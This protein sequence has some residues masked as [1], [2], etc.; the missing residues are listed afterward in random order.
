MRRKFVDTTP[1]VLEIPD[2]TPDEELPPERRWEEED[3]VTRET[4]DH[5]Q[6]LQKTDEA[7]D[8]DVGEDEYYEFPF[9]TPDALD[10]TSTG[11]DEPDVSSSIPDDETVRDN[12]WN[13]NRRRREEEPPASGKRVRFST[14]E[15]EEASRENT[16]DLTKKLTE[17]L[18]QQKADITIQELF[19][20]APYCKELMVKRLI[21]APEQKREEE[22]PTVTVSSVSPWSDTGPVVQVQ[23]K[24]MTLPNILVDG[25]SGANVISAQL[26]S[27]LKGLQLL[28]AP[29]NLK[30][31]DQRRVLPLGVIKELPIR[32]GDMSFQ[33]DAVVLPVSASGEQVP[34]ILGRP[35]LRKN[36]IRQEWDASKDYMELKWRGENRRIKTK[37]VFA[38]SYEDM[39][40]IPHVVSQHRIK[41]L[42]TAKP[43]VQRPYRMNPNYA[44][45]VRKEIEKLKAANFIFPVK[46]YDWLSPI[47]IVSKKNGTL[48]VCVDYRKLNEHTVKDPYPLPFIDDILDKVAGKEA[49]T[50]MDGFSGYNQVS[51]A[52]EDQNKTAFITP[53]GAYAYSRMPFGLSGAP[54]TFQRLVIETFSEYIGDFMEA[55]LDDFTVYG[56]DKR[57]LEQLEKALV[58]CLDK[59]LSLNPDKCVFWTQSG[60][61]LGHIICKEGILMDPA[62]IEKILKQPAPT[63]RKELQRVMGM[64]NF[65]RRYILN[66]AVITAPVNSLDRDDVP[67]EWDKRCDEAF[68]LLKEKMT[69][70][71]ILRPPRWD[72]PFHIHTD[73]SGV[74]VGAVLAQPQDPKLDLPIY[75]A[76]RTLNKNER[77][78]TTTE[79]E[80]LAMVYAEFD[81]TVVYKPGKLNMV[82]DQ[83][84]RQELGREPGYEDDS[85]PDE[86]LLSITLDVPDDHPASGSESEGSEKTVPSYTALLK[87]GWQSPL[88]YFLANGELPEDTPYHLKRRITKKI[89]Q[90]TLIHGELYKRGVDQIL[91]RCVNEEDVLKIMEEAHE[92]PSGGHGAG[93]ATAQKILH[94]GLWWPTLFKDCHT[95]VKS[96]DECQR[97]LTLKEGMPLKPIYP[98]GIFQRWGLDFIGPIKPA[99]WPTGRRYII[100]ATDYTTKWIEAECYRTN[101]KKVTAKFIYENII[102]RFGVPLEFVSD[103]G[104]HFLNGVMEE[105][106]THYQIKHR[107]STAYYPQCNGQ[108]ESTNKILISALRKL[109]EKHRHNWDA[110]VPSVLWAM[111]TA[112]KA[113]TNH[114][115]FHMVYGVEALVPMEFI[116]P[117]LRIATEY[118]L[119]AEEGIQERLMQLLKLEE[120]R[121]VAYEHQCGIQNRRKKY[122]DS[123]RKMFNLKKDDKV[124]H[125]VTT[126]KIKKRKLSYIWEGPFIVREVY[127]NGTFK[128]SDEDQL[129]V[130][131]INGNKL[132]PYDIRNFPRGDPFIDQ[133][134]EIIWEV[135]N[136]DTGPNPEEGTEVPVGNPDTDRNH[137]SMTL[138]K[139]VQTSSRKSGYE[140]IIWIKRQNNMEDPEK[141]PT[142][143]YINNT[144]SRDIKNFDK[145]G[146]GNSAPEFKVEQGRI[147]DIDYPCYS[148]T[149]ESVPDEDHKL[150][151]ELLH[152]PGE[153][154]GI[155]FCLRYSFDELTDG[156]HE[157]PRTKLSRRIRSAMHPVQT[158][159]EL[160]TSDMQTE[161]LSH[162]TLDHMPKNPPACEVSDP[163]GEEDPVSRLLAEPIQKS[164]RVTE[165]NSASADASARG[166]GASEARTDRT[167][168]RGAERSRHPDGG[169]EPQYARRQQAELGLRECEIRRES[170]RSE[171]LAVIRTGSGDCSR[172]TGLREEESRPEAELIENIL[173]VPN[174]ASNSI[175]RTERSL[176]RSVLIHR[177]RPILRPCR[178]PY[179]IE[180]MSKKGSASKAAISELHTNNEELLIA[181]DKAVKGRKILACYIKDIGNLEW[182]DE[183][184]AEQ[185]KKQFGALITLKLTQIQPDLIAQLANA[186][187]GVTNRVTISKAS[188][189]I[190]EDLIQDVFNLPN[191]GVTISKLPVLDSDWLAVAYPEYALPAKNRK[192]YYTAARCEHPDW[193]SKISWVIRYVLGRA[194]G[195]KISKGVLA[196]MLEA[197]AKGVTVNWAQV[198]TDRLRTELR[199]LKL[200]TKGEFYR[201]EAG[202]QLTMLGLYMLTGRDF[203]SDEVKEKTGSK[204]V[205]AKIEKTVPDTPSCRTRGKRKAPEPKKVVKR[206]NRRRSP[207]MEAEVSSPD[208]SSEEESEGERER[209]P[210]PEY[211]REGPH[212]KKIW[213]CEGPQAAENFQ[214]VSR[215]PKPIVVK[216]EAGE[217]SAS[218]RAP[219]GYG[220][221]PKNAPTVTE[222]SSGTENE[223]SPQFPIPDP[224][225]LAQA[226]FCWEMEPDA[227]GPQPTGSRSTHRSGDRYKAEYEKTVKGKEISSPPT[228]EIPVPGQTA[229]GEVRPWERMGM[230]TV[231]AT[232]VIQDIIR[233]TIQPTTEPNPA[234]QMERVRRQAEQANRS[235]DEAQ[236]RAFAANPLPETGR[237]HPAVSAPSGIDQAGFFRAMQ[238]RGYTEFLRANERIRSTDALMALDPEFRE[239]WTQLTGFTESLVRSSSGVFAVMQELFTTYDLLTW[240]RQNEKQLREELVHCQRDFNMLYMQNMELTAILRILYETMDKADPHGSFYAEFQEQLRQSQ[241]QILKDKES[242][243]P[244]VTTNDAP[245]GGRAAPDEGTS[246]RPS[247]GDR[248]TTAAPPSRSQSGQSQA[249]G[250]QLPDSQQ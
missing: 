163:I 137:Y 23:I 208:P 83:L 158:E 182:E 161:E 12:G 139:P 4:I 11:P 149:V 200:V 132:R 177:L 144:V 105:L 148:I 77:D 171:E 199:K 20:L 248:P 40:G 217:P 123:H 207:S 142:R 202:P 35:W 239:R 186:Y 183:E 52:T 138:I 240:S 78:Y 71:P 235:A 204:K 231:R 164:A 249:P 117:T 242:M 63:N 226:K 124:L 233:G 66:Y 87:E 145:T 238:H 214:L 222:L 154:G 243:F 21:G 54:A 203:D 224:I 245:E 155:K 94:T 227:A 184:E 193:R 75:F 61:L 115:P 25:G 60:I 36:K 215:K 70:G 229:K 80:A 110:S 28:H 45:A 244:P 157:R 180:A 57:H 50:F 130:R 119:N 68:N 96:C 46:E 131:V 150:T 205:T 39:K 135:N 221:G 237:A 206:V 17:R 102:T 112:Y 188:W 26:Y 109:V 210:T 62:K 108:A 118:S 125:C 22:N 6:E 197:E 79:R 230:Q 122:I 190:D 9:P 219:P 74:A 44:E 90:Y 136:Q 179:R 213:I 187:N 93:E 212:P 128:I 121:E 73:A 18:L 33:I 134:E 7:D 104:G 19:E 64:T 43:L 166:F 8:I 141:R 209:S 225:E 107:F 14:A 196:A 59:Q 101:D 24:G 189:L 173:S 53:W 114:T 2:V 34:M 48:R 170:D 218:Q 97:S 228:V 37:P 156:L 192:E 116:V 55:F 143:N 147:E 198:V 169:S 91:R 41:L 168:Q 81:F 51:I 69:Q 85:F 72:M 95:H 151:K 176:N 16:E 181:G 241:E 234:G 49:Y 42:P 10:V 127:A 65:Y 211:L 32:I 92:G 103:Q 172:R 167:D 175:D 153:Y 160:V 98:I 232:N 76:S 162:V 67:Y 140:K 194:E 29:F 100:T 1:E 216:V 5:I 174:F 86:H 89:K 84:S 47:V 146:D 120:A 56:P 31:A 27:K 82:A 220:G 223:R 185:W 250:T 126:G 13:R 178:T 38:W 111:R 247:Q 191:A 3:R 106:T 195:R 15:S 236:N 129:D 99:T 113:T 246:S 88:R 201:C 165:S 133:V 30:M 152:I 58:R 159:R